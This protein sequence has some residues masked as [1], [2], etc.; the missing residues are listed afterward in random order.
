MEKI[1]YFYGQWHYEVRKHEKK[2]VF[3]ERML[4]REELFDSEKTKP[5]HYL[6]IIEDLLD[7][8]DAHLVRDLFIKGSHHVNISVILLTQNL[9]LLVCS[10]EWYISLM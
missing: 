4:T 3:Q 7:P 9:F 8:E 6:L 10:N 2:V 5:G 1:L